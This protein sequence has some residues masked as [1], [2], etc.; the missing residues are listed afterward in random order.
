MT[1][2]KLIC[3]YKSSE[4]AVKPEIKD[5]IKGDSLGNVYELFTRTENKWILCEFC[6]DLRQRHKPNINEFITLQTLKQ[7]PVYH[8]YVWIH[9]YTYEKQEYESA[10]ILNEQLDWL[11]ILQVLHNERTIIENN[12]K[13]SII[14]SCDYGKNKAAIWLVLQ[15]IYINFFKGV[16]HSFLSLLKSW[17]DG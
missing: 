4:S 13:V 16:C 6:Y 8:I 11:E 10:K 12:K 5:C 3:D 7:V 1:L 14:S 2:V 17:A 15:Y 9:V